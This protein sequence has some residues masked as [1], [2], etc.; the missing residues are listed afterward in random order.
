MRRLTAVCLLGLSKI[1]D[2][3]AASLLD[4]A[5][6]RAIRALID[7]IVISRLLPSFPADRHLFPSSLERFTRFPLGTVLLC[8]P[9]PTRSGS[10]I[11][12]KPTAPQLVNGVAACM[13][14][15]LISLRQRYRYVNESKILGNGAPNSQTR[16]AVPQLREPSH[17]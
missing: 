14:M 13:G 9:W 16:A 5:S 3:H 8:I 6:L 1:P 10:A 4:S 12:V 2:G 7:A 15:H 11:S 17:C